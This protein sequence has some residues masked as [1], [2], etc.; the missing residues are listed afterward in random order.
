MKQN[1]FSSIIIIITLCCACVTITLQAQNAAA[2]SSNPGPGLHVALSW[3]PTENAV[4]Y[5][6]FRSTTAGTYPSTPLAMVNPAANCAA[7]QSLLITSPDSVAWKLVERALADSTTLFNPCNINTLPANSEKRNRLLMLARRSIP[8]AKAIG[9][10]YQDNTVMNG[11]TY[12][13]RIVALNAGNAVIGTV[14]T[15]LSVTAGTFTA[16]P[17]P[18]GI[19]VE[20]GDA[21]VLVRWDGVNS[22]AGFIVERSTNPMGGFQRI[23]PSFYTMQLTNHLNGDTLIPNTEGLL[24]FQR[25]DTLGRPITHLV[26]G[27]AINGPTNGVTYYYRVRS[28]DLFNRQGLPSVVSAGA[29]PLDSTKPAAPGDLLITPD[30]ISGHVN[31]RW[32]LVRFDENGHRDSV[33]LYRIYRFENAEDP[34]TTPSVL[35]GSV[36][37]LNNGQ[38]ERDFT[39]TDPNLRS[40][41]G[42]RKWWY[43]LRAYDLTG[44][45]SQYSTAFSATV[46]DTTPPAIAK[47]LVTNPFEDRIEMSWNLNSETDIAGYAV[48]R[49]LCHRGEWVECD[50]RSQYDCPEKQA[51]YQYLQTLE[52]TD[53]EEYQRLLAVI[54]KMP[55]PCS[56]DFV[57]LGE[58][59]HDSAQIAQG[60]SRAMFIDRTLPAGSPLCY[61]YWIKAKD[62]SGNL[63][64]TYPLPSIDEQAEIVCER[65]RDRTPPEPALISGLFA[66]DNSIR[67]EWIG[68]PTQDTRAY[69][70]Y[71]AEAPNAI[72]EPAIGDY[73]WVGGRTV[74]TPPATPVSLTEPYKAP[75]VPECGVI[76]VQ[77]NQWM[78]EGFLE[79][80]VD[81][82]KTYWYRVVAID[83]DG[84]EG[85]LDK[86]APISSFTFNRQQA[87]APIFDALTPQP[88]PCGI[89]LQWS[90]LYDASQHNGFIIYRSTSA[91]GAFTPISVSLIQSNTFQDYQV[92]KGKTYWYRLAVMMKNGRLSHLS[93]AQSVVP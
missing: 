25:W 75:G 77:G 80:K 8:I 66:R 63:S 29:M 13:Y 70:V 41:F 2:I 21:A 47:G 37:P 76:P 48:Y 35:V 73:K 67:I 88:D 27:F 9:I 60:A 23:N 26:N 45:E 17:A 92:V 14:A 24:D 89:V 90:P 7:V 38:W 46:K 22:A 20:P 91:G 19:A 83:Y 82:K 69:H 43:R 5:Q 64:G 55:C 12:F 28:V 56:G 32:N 93:T 44:N 49:S 10:A 72:V 61:A 11:T 1:I 40:D 87:A 85:S 34:T 59:T 81:P 50:P 6:V 31:I 74:E 58:I 79:D 78:S 68:P 4:R 33:N 30:S 84:N 3:T 86:A 52:R 51:M 16:P 71:R 15:D 18:T 39:D 62:G 36:A 57:Y 54:R 65:L 42:D 53:P